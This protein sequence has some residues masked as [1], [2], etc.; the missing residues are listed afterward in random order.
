MVQRFKVASFEAMDD[1]F[2]RQHTLVAP[3]IPVLLSTGMMTLEDV[4]LQAAKVG[5]LGGVLHC[6]SAYPTPTQEAHLDSIYQMRRML[7][8]V[9][10]G[11]SDHTRSITTGGL[12]VAAGAQILE[13]HC[14]LEGTPLNNADYSSALGPNALKEYVDY[15]R[16][17]ELMVGYGVKRVQPSEEPMLRFRVKP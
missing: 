4:A 1:V 5:H 15:A 16:K 11:F 3:G 2:L 12:A 7:S 8:P 10:V 17:V 14:R 6:V 9:P 13:V